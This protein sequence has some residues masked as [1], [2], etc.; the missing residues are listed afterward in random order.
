MSS[1]EYSTGGAGI[2]AIHAA[3][4]SRNRACIARDV[5]PAGRERGAGAVEADRSGEAVVLE[6]P[7]GE[8]LGQ[9]PARGAQ[10]QV[11]LEQALAG[12]DE[13]LREPEIVERAAL[14]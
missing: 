10:Q 9:A 4:P 12:R 1:S 7:V 5:V 3:Q 13:A 8:D 6:R 11:E 14:M 2:C